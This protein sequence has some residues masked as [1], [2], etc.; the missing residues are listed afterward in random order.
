[1]QRVILFSVHFSLFACWCIFQARKNREIT[2]T[3]G[4][5]AFGYLQFVEQSFQVI[6][7]NVVGCTLYNNVDNTKSISFF[8]HV[9]CTGRV[10]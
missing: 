9:Y 3:V 7:L 1:M 8:K 2:C 5:L 10:L 4:D 6:C